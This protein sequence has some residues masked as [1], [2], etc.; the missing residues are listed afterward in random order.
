MNQYKISKER[1]AELEWLF[2]TFDKQKN[3]IDGN[4]MLYVLRSIGI[5]LPKNDAKAL[6]EECRINGNIKL[7]NFFAFMQELYYDENVGKR[8]LQGLQAH[9][10]KNAKSIHA[11]RL[12]DLL[13]SL[14]T[15]VR[16]TED[17]V[18]FF[19]NVECDANTHKDI[20]FDEFIYRILKEWH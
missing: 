6:L 12:K 5:Y 2:K 9:T 8:L 15:G 7:N 19:L 20:P 14:G 17:E 18:D 1:R 16:L 11:S 3:G 13:M 4:T 10:D